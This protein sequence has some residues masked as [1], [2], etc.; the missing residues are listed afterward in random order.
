MDQPLHYNTFFRGNDA[1]CGI[2][3]QG[4][5]LQKLALKQSTEPTHL[6]KTFFK[7]DDASGG[8]IPEIVSL[9]TLNLNKSTE[10]TFTYKTSCFKAMMLH[11]PSSPET[12]SL[13]TLTLNY[14]T[15]STLY[16]NTSLSLQTLTLN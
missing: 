10:P 6:T 5:S 14:S 1:S 15:E 2:I 12:V 13:Q 7:G 11:V 8:N 16:Y 3:P 4:V 9:Q